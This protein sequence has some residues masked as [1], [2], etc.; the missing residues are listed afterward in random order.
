MKQS[1]DHSGEFTYKNNV[2]VGALQTNRTNYLLPLLKFQ[3]EFNEQ[4][5][6]RKEGGG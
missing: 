5:C 3:I 2:D 6:R 1:I 4:N